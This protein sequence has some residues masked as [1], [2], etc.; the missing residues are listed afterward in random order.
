VLLLLFFQPNKARLMLETHSTKATELA[1]V[2]M[3]G[4][5][6]EPSA[7]GGQWEFGGEAP[8][9]AAILQLFFQKYAFL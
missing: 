5:G 8:D 2:T 9:A 4:L 1:K 7:A 6:T 3:R